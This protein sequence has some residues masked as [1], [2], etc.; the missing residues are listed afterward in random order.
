MVV[1]EMP[2]CDSSNLVHISSINSIEFPDFDDLPH[3]LRDFVFNDN[4]DYRDQIKSEKTRKHF[5][6]IS[7]FQ[8]PPNKNQDSDNDEPP[9]SNC[10][11]NSLE[12]MVN[13]FIY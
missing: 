1:D 7:N 4:S 8:M 11:G 2:H 12:S 9:S 10:N 5:A 13:R 3:H 6:N